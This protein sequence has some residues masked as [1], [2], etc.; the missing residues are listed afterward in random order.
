MKFELTYMNRVTVS[1]AVG[2][3]LGLCQA[4]TAVDITISDP[5]GKNSFGTDAR[6]VVG[7]NEDQNVTANCVAS[8]TWDMEAF[9]VQPGKLILIG[10]FDMKNGVYDANWKQTFTSGDIF[11]NTGGS[12]PAPQTYPSGTANGY[13]T[14]NN[15]GWEYAIDVD[16]ANLKFQVD[17]LTAGCTLTTGYFRQN[18]AANPYAVD[19]LGTGPGAGTVVNNTANK[20]V[21]YQTGLTDAQVL[22]LYGV[23]LK[24][25]THNVASF[26]MSWFNTE[27]G[28][29]ASTLTHFSI[30]C[31][32]DEVLGYMQGGFDVPD[33]GSTLMLLGLAL[34]GLG[35][36]RRRLS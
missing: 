15:N 14:Y 10:G 19:S 7:V 4:A 12:T 1:I 35:L 26:D 23:D 33:Y 31:N 11:F 34:G 17:K 20:D 3:L 6:S 21:E 18:D 32:N 29:T 5:L 36:A 16:W 9:V 24:G 8:Q 27:V 25:G 2:A 13:N 22:A 30:S 28:A